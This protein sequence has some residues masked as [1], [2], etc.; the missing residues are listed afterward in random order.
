MILRK[1]W[2]VNGIIELVV[3]L[4]EG[5]FGEMRYYVLVRVMIGI[6]GVVL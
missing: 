3:L 1:F 4:V 6:K 5:S 2:S